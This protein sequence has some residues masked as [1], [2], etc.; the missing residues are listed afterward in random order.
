MERDQ[1]LLLKEVLASEGHLKI[2]LYGMSMHPIIAPG[3]EIRIEPID[4]KKINKFDLVAFFMNSFLACH[5]VWQARPE[6][7]VCRSYKYSR[8]DRVETSNILGR[9]TSHR[10]TWLQQ[11][12]CMANNLFSQESSS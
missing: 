1:F 9:V 5:Y 11:M 12:R 2:K 6:E 7:W 3:E 8:V 10:I 4:I